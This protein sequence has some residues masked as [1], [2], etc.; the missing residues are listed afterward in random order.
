MNGIRSWGVVLAISM[1]KSHIFQP[2]EKVDLKDLL[3]KE[4]MEETLYFT[5]KKFLRYNTYQIQSIG[6]YNCWKFSLIAGHFQPP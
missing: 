2:P 3:Q 1:L 6:I 5:D 4:G